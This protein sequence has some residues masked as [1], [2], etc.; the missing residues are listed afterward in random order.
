M[1][2]L[3]SSMGG[4][5]GSFS[6]ILPFVII[7]AFL[8]ST[9]VLGAYL[10]SLGYRLYSHLRYAEMRRFKALRPKITEHR[11][12]T[13][14]LHTIPIPAPPTISTRS[15]NE[16]LIGREARLLIERRNLFKELKQ[17]DIPIPANTDRVGGANLVVYLEF[18][19]DCAARGDLKDAR[20]P[21]LT[22]L[23]TVDLAS[24]L[25]T[26]ANN[27]PSPEA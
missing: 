1:Y 26:R 27:T 7:A 24:F 17:F 22:K 16:M 15:R 19:E 8:V 23:L 2:G 25:R 5:L 12:R 20:N 9:L 10:G 18:L 14:G 4:A 11:E 13:L 21:N 6:S 3:V